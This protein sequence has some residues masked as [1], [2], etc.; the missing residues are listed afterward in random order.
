MI[1]ARRVSNEESVLFAIHDM[2][3][4]LYSHGNAFF[5]VKCTY[6]KSGVECVIPPIIDTNEPIRADGGEYLAINIDQAAVV[7]ER[8]LCTRGHAVLRKYIWTSDRRVTIR[9]DD[10]IVELMLYLIGLIY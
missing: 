4:K 2:Y 8:S 7:P 6:L 9:I 5:N 3:F 1:T 10:E